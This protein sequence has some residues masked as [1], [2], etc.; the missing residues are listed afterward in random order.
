MTQILSWNIQNGKGV[1]DMVS[2]P[3]IAEVIRSMGDHDMIC[4]QEVSR[5]LS[6]DGSGDRPDQVGELAE[7]FPGYEVVFGAAIDA[8]DNTGGHRWQFG[9]VLLTRLPMLSIQHH[10]LPRPA[11]GN[12]RHMTRQAMEVVI[13]SESGPLR[14]VNLHLEYHSLV[15][16]LAQVDRLRHLQAETMAE[17]DE[18]PRTDPDGAYRA[19]PRPVDAIYCGDFNML[20][21]SSE[22]RL[23]LSPL[24]GESAL[25]QDAWTIVN[26]DAPHP[27]TCGVFDHVH[28]PEGPHCR[29]FFFVAGECVGLVD[30]VSVNTETAASDHQPLVLTLLN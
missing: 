24:G 25:F 10:V 26:P 5:G 13:A 19:I 29:D 17:Y 8:L 11:D 6:L 12:V 7:L 3:R 30:G 28:W 2:L 16:R 23:L 4:L 27:P 1:D 9:N 20:A 21:D 14:I 15:Q 18:P 22:Y